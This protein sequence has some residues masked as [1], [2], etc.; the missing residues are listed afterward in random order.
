LRNALDHLPRKSND[1]CLTELRWLYDRRDAAEARQH[2]RR[3]LDLWSP[4][5]PKL[6]SW[7]EENI[8]QTW[9]FYRQ[10]REHHKHIK[11]TNLLE[12]PNQ[13]IKRR[14]RVAS[15]FPNEASLLRLVSALLAETSDD[16]QSSKTYL[17]MHPSFP[18]SA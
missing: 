6:C 7:V 13:E 18:T 15:I 5:H 2:L 9:T 17:N 14:T 12:R 8:E 4:K 11:S 10:P 3:W 1:D 16:W